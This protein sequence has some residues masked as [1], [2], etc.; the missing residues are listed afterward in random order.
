MRNNFMFF[1][2]KKNKL[3]FFGLIIVLISIFFVAVGPYIVPYSPV[4]LS[5]KEQLLAPS[6]NHWFGTDLNGMDIFSRVIAAY[7][8]DLFIA[9]IGG[10]IAMIIGGPVGVFVGYFDGKGGIF[11]FIA[12]VI[13]RIIDVIQAFPLIILGLLLVA[14]FGAGPF[15]IIFLIAIGNIPTNIRLARTETLALRDKLFVEAARAQ[16]I[17]EAKIAFK[18]I[19]PNSINQVIALLSMSMG[20]GILFTAGISFVGAGVQVPTPEWGLMI[21]AGAAQMITG[22]WWTALFPGIF[23]GV[24]V[25]GFSMLGQVLTDLIDPLKRVELGYRR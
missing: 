3:Q 14:G 5:V 18:E 10:L 6:I 8:I 25:F 22:Q 23:M 16:G 20:F 1:Y 19:L 2:L 17:T 11:G 9:F 24:T 7:R 12:T 4:A 13:L 15:N 21:S